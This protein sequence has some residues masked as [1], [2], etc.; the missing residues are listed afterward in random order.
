MR[1]GCA[2]RC[3]TSLR[4]QAALV[5][6][7]GVSAQAIYHKAADFSRIS[8]SDARAPLPVAGAF[9]AASG[10]KT[11]I[12]RV[13]GR[14]R[15]LRRLCQ[16]CCLPAPRRSGAFLRRGEAV[17]TRS[18]APRRRRARRQRHR[19][20]GRPRDGHRPGRDA[21]GGAAPRRTAAL[22]NGREREALHHQRQLP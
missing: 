5:N 3:P 17:L 22:A 7:K 9:A 20:W 4:E 21:A 10:Y 8:C 18:R 2:E 14:P 16:S 11:R 19:G 15:G 13:A 1:R 6:R 12:G